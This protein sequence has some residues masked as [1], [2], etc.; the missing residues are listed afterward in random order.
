MRWIV[1]RKE[2]KEDAKE[3]RLRYGW[4]GRCV[5]TRVGE[6]SDIWGKRQARGQ[7]NQISLG[8]THTQDTFKCCLTAM[9]LVMMMILWK[10]ESLVKVRCTS[11]YLTDP[12]SKNCFVFCSIAIS[13]AT[14]EIF[15]G[16]SM[17]SKRFLFQ[18]FDSLRIAPRPPFQRPLPPEKAQQSLILQALGV[19]KIHSAMCF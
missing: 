8:T 19:P 6:M 18:A 4:V 11:T 5:W 17:A 3:Q 7:R 14:L 16:L 15:E 1:V 9:D 10:I 2:R 13:H 12:K